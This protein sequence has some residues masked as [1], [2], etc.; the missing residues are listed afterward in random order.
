MPYVEPEVK[1]IETNRKL[2][3]YAGELGFY[4]NIMILEDSILDMKEDL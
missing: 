2:D 1:R 4:L 3:N